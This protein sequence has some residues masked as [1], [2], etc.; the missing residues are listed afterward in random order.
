MTITEQQW[1]Q[2]NDE[3]KNSFQDEVCK[4]FQNG[5]YPSWVNVHLFLLK[6]NIIE[7]TLGDKE[8]P[9]VEENIK[10]LWKKVLNYFND[11]K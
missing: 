9:Q 4:K 7:A 1:N 11:K 6:R 2:L 10:V 8:T 5:V 3:Q